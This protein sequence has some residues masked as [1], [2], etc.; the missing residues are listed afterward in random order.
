M[1]NSYQEESGIGR[2]AEYPND[3]DQGFSVGL[4]KLKRHLGLVGTT[5][6]L[7]FLIKHEKIF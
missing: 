4:T 1:L 2:I 3:I 5:N 7:G 6:L